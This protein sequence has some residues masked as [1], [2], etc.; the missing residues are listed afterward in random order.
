[1]FCESVQT[2]EKRENLHP[3]K[4]TGYTVPG[5][6]LYS[7]PGI[8]CHK[9]QLQSYTLDQVQRSHTKIVMLTHFF[10]R[11]ILSAHANEN[12]VT[13]LICSILHVLQLM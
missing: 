1:M 4:L 9:Y 6:Q 8:L 10:A 3:A 5:T 7:G 13:F 11:L 2:R 12:D